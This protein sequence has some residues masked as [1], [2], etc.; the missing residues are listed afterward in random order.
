[1]AHR[2]CL[3]GN[4]CQTEAEWHWQAYEEANQRERELRQQLRTILELIKGRGVPKTPEVLSTVTTDDLNR[5]ERE[6]LESEE[7]L[8]L[9]RGLQGSPRQRPPHRSPE[10]EAPLTFVERSARLSAETAETPAAPFPVSGRGATPVSPVDEEKQGGH[11]PPSLVVYCLGSLR[12]YNNEQS[13]EQ[14]PNQKCKSIFKYMIGHRERPIH[15]EI[16]MDLFWRDADP[17]AARRNLY[18]AIYNLRQALQTGGPDFPY[19]LCEESCYRL[20]PE[21]ELWVDSEAFCLHY[22]TGQRLEHEGRLLEAIREY[23]LAENLYEG[24]FLAQDRYEDWLFDH[25]E[26]LKRAYLDILGRLSQHYFDQEQFATC[27]A[28]CQKILSEDNC[29]EDA[30]QRLMRCYLRQGQRHLALRQ[31]HL[32]V[33]ALERELDVPPMPATV[34]LY[35][36]IQKNHFNFQAP[37]N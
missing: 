21:L 23:E 7:R 34:E 16:L 17:K 12:V 6:P 27:I 36:E 1:A 24:E 15:S 5:L 2:I 3:A 33:E 19:I 18:Q 13:I 9:R 25:R 10:S 29:H 26:H 8:G 20:N 30:H 11:A 28:F 32:C 35:Q 14:W 22:Q 4:Q 31:Y 37:E